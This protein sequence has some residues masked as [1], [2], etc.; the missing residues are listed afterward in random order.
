MVYRHGR[1]G[2]GDLP[3]LV[4]GKDQ[5]MR[6]SLKLGL[7]IAIT[8]LFA[9]QAYANPCPPGNPPTNCGPPAGAILDLNDTPVPHTYQQYTTSFTA[10]N[11]TTNVSFSFRED[12]AFLGLDD[13]SVTTGGGANLVVNS[14][15][16]L[17]V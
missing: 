1:S 2:S 6:N 3:R 8:I 4:N 9:S 12:P 10:T 17:G 14:G 5:R 15:F 11:T 16:E 7:L 13:V